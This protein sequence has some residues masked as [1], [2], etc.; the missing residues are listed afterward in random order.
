MMRFPPGTI[1]KQKGGHAFEQ[2]PTDQPVD[3]CG[4]EPA[5]EERDSVDRDR[6]GLRRHPHD[7]SA[8]GFREGR[9]RLER[10][11]HL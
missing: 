11:A 6:R 9:L 1:T 8:I 7:Q 3:R 2:V 4:L 10:A 5:V